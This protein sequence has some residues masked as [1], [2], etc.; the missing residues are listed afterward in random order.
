VNL[1]D[2]FVI[3]SSRTIVRGDKFSA[4]IVMAAVDT[5]QVP[6]IYIGGQ[7]VNLKDG[8][9][10]RVCTATG[11]FTLNGYMETVNGNGDKIRRDFSQQY[12]VVDPSATV[13]ADLMNVLYAGYNNP[14]SISVPG[15][16]LNKISATM[17]GGSLQSSGPG[18]YI[19]RPSAV[20][21]DVTFTVM[22][23]E[24]AL[25]EGSSYAAQAYQLLQQYRRNSPRVQIRF[26][27]LAENPAFAARY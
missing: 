14:I 8:I 9:Y 12:T 11:D 23:K 21:Q 16:P 1:L 25:K 15:V 2:A 26:V 10:E 27:D 3:P 20:G 5:T 17:S 19:A 18:R 13:S 24:E 6:D 22:N 4:R 7:K